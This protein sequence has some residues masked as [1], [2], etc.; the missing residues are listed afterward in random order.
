MGRWGCAARRSLEHC[1]GAGAPTWL[2]FPEKRFCTHSAEERRWGLFLFDTYRLIG[3]FLVLRRG[4]SYARAGRRVCGDSRRIVCAMRGK[5]DLAQLQLK[6]FIAHYHFLPGLSRR[7]PLFDSLRVLGD[8]GEHRNRDVAV[9]VVVKCSFKPGSNP[10][11]KLSVAKS[12]TTPSVFITGL[13]MRQGQ[14]LSMTDIRMR[15]RTSPHRKGTTRARS[16]RIVRPGP[17]RNGSD[18]WIQR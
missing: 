14:S 16:E 12:S 9:F 13:E 8:S 7:E 17:N 3:G 2:T 1:A 10:E 15:H 18:S 11:D 6:V 5:R 4:C